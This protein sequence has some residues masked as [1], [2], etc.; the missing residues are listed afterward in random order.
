MRIAI[1]P[2]KKKSGQLD[3]VP[4]QYHC[5]DQKKNVHRDEHVLVWSVPSYCFLSEIDGTDDFFEEKTP[6]TCCLGRF[7][8][9]HDES[10]HIVCSFSLLRVSALLCP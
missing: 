4:L 5:T 2:N 9:E 7:T 1:L 3:D 10:D 6:S 8:L